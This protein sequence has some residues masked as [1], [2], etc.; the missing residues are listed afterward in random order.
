MVQGLNE[1]NNRVPPS[2]F[3]VKDSETK[4]SNYFFVPKSISKLKNDTRPIVLAYGAWGA[5]SGRPNMVCNKG[6]P[7]CIGVSLMKKL[8]KRYIVSL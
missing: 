3:L 7:P 5:I 2:S 1:Y 4:K 8:S 6:N